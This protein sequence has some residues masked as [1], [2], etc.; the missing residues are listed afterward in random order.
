MFLRSF[1]IKKILLCSVDLDKWEVFSF[2]DMKSLKKN[3]DDIHRLQVMEISLFEQ[4]TKLRHQLNFLTDEWYVANH[5]LNSW[6]IFMKKKKVLAKVELKWEIPVQKMRK[7]IPVDWLVWTELLFSK[8]IVI[9]FF[10]LFNFLEKSSQTT[11][12]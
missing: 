8:F 2:L 10:Q 11:C 12:L 1:F 4:K 3:S 5:S 6:N 9:H 7:N